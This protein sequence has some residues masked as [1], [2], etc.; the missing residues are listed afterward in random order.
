[1]GT[2][3]GISACQSSIGLV[4][5][6]WEKF[7]KSLEYYEKA[8]IIDK[9]IGK[10]SNIAIRFKNIGGVYYA[11]GKYEKA[12]EYFKKA[13]EIDEEL[14]QKNKLPE[15]FNNIGG[16][17]HSWRQYVN[18]IEFYQKALA[19]YQQIGNKSGIANVLSNIGSIYLAQKNYTQAEEYFTKSIAIKEELRL[20]A[21]GPVRRDYLASQ[22]YTY[23][24]LVT[25]YIHNNKPELAFD[26][27]ELSSAKYLAEQLKEKIGGKNL[28]FSGIAAYQPK[29]SKD[30][31][32]ISLANIEIDDS[33][34]IAVSQNSIHTVE[35]NKQAFI[36]SIFEQH[37]T[38][39]KEAVS[40][41]RGLKIS[42]E[43]ENQLK[44]NVL[45]KNEFND[46]INYYRYMLTKES[47]SSSEEKI[48]I[49]ISRGLYDLFLSPIEKDM[50]GKS[51]LIIIPDGI[52][53][54]LPFETLLLPSDQYLVE[55]YHIKYTQSLTVL[56][57][58]A[59]RI[60][61][62]DRSPLLAFG[63]AVYDTTSYET[64]MIVSAQQL[65]CLQQETIA[66]LDKGLSVRNAYSK[67]GLSRLN[68][69][70]GTLTEVKAIGGIV[71]GSLIYTGAD[72]SEMT[73]KKLSREG[74]LRKFKV[75]HFA[76][77][78]IFIQDMPEL[79]AI[80]LSLFEKERDNEDGYLTMKEI[81]MLDFNADFVNLSACDTGLGKIYGGE[82]LV[83]L[84]QSF[85]L[86]GANGLSV[87]LWQVS[88]AS[89]MEFM[90][91]LY[92]LVQEKVISYDMAVTEMKRI[93]I[94]R[95]NQGGNDYRR[96]FFWAPF[97]YYGK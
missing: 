45:K 66:A 31:L 58:L 34:V 17:Y 10:K 36:A 52:L 21:P 19:I 13:L 23:R 11:W 48:F 83:G 38:E 26:T 47:L 80:V 70:P 12:L 39:I 53:W 64:D 18:A 71:A 67:L 49:K 43:K 25:T 20:T 28:R 35:V 4:Y 14:G 46:I 78:G 65:Q 16:I 56:E 76:T 32:I 61:K 24:W 57:L 97:V 85:L 73:I 81:A 55:K 5:F 3:E 93:F 86:A 44:I 7:D 79:S 51:V 8:L 87:S 90:T 68:N 15:D 89:T 9:Q 95:Q 1:M 22:I 30:C 42:G 96:P 88:D 60:Y 40:G 2:K 41:L 27:V 69:L 91:G 37:E 72:A 77:H 94:R 84:T 62:A 29:I 75:V 92:K 33:A 74:Q 63:G 82:G 50:A 6:A 54:N 59:S